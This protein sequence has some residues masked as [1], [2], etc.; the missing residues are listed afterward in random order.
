M[1]DILE[2][3]RAY[4]EKLHKPALKP[5][6]GITPL[7]QIN[8]LILVNDARLGDSSADEKVRIQIRGGRNEDAEI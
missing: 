4:F 3:W 6:V 7:F 2:R 1:E 5:V 8:S